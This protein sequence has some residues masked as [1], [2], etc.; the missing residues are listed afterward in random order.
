[1][2]EKQKKRKEAD[3]GKKKKSNIDAAVIDSLR[4]PQDTIWLRDHLNALIIGVDAPVMARFNRIL[5]RGRESDPKTWEEFLAADLRDRGIGQ[6]EYGDNVEACLKI[7]RESGRIIENV[8][9]QRDLESKLQEILNSYGIE[10][11]PKSKENR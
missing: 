4:H 3:L 8:G 5:A 11:N 6:P 9:S 7:A 1:M 2:K 10:G